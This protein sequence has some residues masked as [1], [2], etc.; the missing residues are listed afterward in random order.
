MPDLPGHDRREERRAERE[1]RERGQ[2]RRRKG[3]V[4]RNADRFGSDEEA[5]ASARLELPDP[6]PEPDDIDRRSREHDERWRE[7]FRD[8]GD[9]E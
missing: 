6:V 4:I 9:A 5:R 7:H 8:E 2:E 3:I 1:A